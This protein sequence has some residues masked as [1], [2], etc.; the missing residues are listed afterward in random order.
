LSA[1]YQS[2]SGRCRYENVAPSS[3]IGFGFRQPRLRCGKRLKGGKQHLELENQGAALHS[4]SIVGA[5]VFPD[6]WRDA[7]GANLNL[8]RLRDRGVNA[9]MT[10][11]DS[12]E[13]SV[14]DATHNAG[15][16]FFAGVACFSDHASNFRYLRERPE[17]WPV[18]ENGAR[19]PQMEWYVG[20]S[21]TDRR[22]Q[23]EALSQIR[24]IART[25]PIDGLFLDF[26]RWPL[27]WEIELRPGRDRPFDSSFDAATLAMFEK[28]TGALPRYLDSTKARAAW[29]R[30]NRLADWVEFKCKVVS[31][32]V[33]EARNAL[34]EAKTDAELGIYV[35]P[36][37]NGLT[38]PLTGQR[39]KDLEPL[40]D[41]MSPML[42]HNILLQPPAWVASTLA[43][44]VQ[45]AGEKTLPVLQ[46]DSNRDPALVADWGPPMSDV[47]WSETLSQ[48][49]GRTDIGGLIVFPGMA[50]M[51]G[52]GASLHAMLAAKQ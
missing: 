11:S 22:R 1:R 52:R 19:R 35:V 39:I 7:V 29:I 48:V 43:P 12:Y 27:H 13:L 6:F 14:V 10:E 16:R 4:K 40:V 34:K 28:A 33:A 41:W 8:T 23:E 5:F 44:M 38:E 49:A 47:A 2:K 37:V 15:L 32:F 51:D 24:L 3:V 17:L 30:R 25:F 18:L 36:D 45:I 21:P 26:V 31:D 50:L 9:I 20:M 46:A 42:Y